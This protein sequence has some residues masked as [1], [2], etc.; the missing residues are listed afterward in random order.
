MGLSDLQHPIINLYIDKEERKVEKMSTNIKGISGSTLK[1]M[2]M[3]CM[4]ADHTGAVVL[5]KVLA[6]AGIVEVWDYSIGH[7]NQ[8]LELGSIGYV[9][10]GYQ[11][12]RNFIGRLA[13]PVFCFLLVEGFQKTHDRGKYAM[14]LAVFAMI[15]EIPFDLAFAGKA[16]EFSHQNVFFSLLLGFLVMQCLSKLPEKVKHMALLWLFQAAVVYAGMVTAETL[17]TDY[18]G[19]SIIAIA[20]IYLFR[21]QKASQ[22]VAGCV[23]FSWE[24]AAPLAFIPIAFYNGKKGLSLKF[25]FYAFYPMHLLILY[26]IALLLIK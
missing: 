6:G 25:I 1:I 15:S 21:K 9:Y 24:P 18:G 14:R 7:I 16:L 8:M 19:Y 17:R 4:L 11:I 22:L 23:A 2:A 3:I 20:L 10:L 5:G 12:L 13:F 26:L